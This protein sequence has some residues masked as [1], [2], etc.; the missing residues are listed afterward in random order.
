[1]WFWHWADPEDAPWDALVALGYDDE[2]AARK[3]AAVAAHRSQVAPLSAAPGDEVLLGPELLD[4]F[5]G[6]QEV[7]LE[8]A[9]TDPTLEDLHVKEVDPWGATRRWY[10]HR[11]RDL[12][13]AALPRRRFTRG[14]ELG[15]SRGE[16]A[17]DLAGRCDALVAVDRSPAAIARARTVVPAHVETAVLDV[18]AQ[19]PAGSFDLVVLSEV[20]YFLSPVA[21]EHLL[22]RVAGCL[23]ERG[24]VVLCHWRHPIDGWVLD[25]ADVHDRVLHTV[26]L[27]PL[28]ARYRDDDVEVLVLAER[29]D[30]P[31]PHE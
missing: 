9:V 11:K 19:W 21:L 13:L 23:S 31:D 6:D 27:P 16:L 25:G 8:D 14:L 4:H 3:T 5:P 7:F 17:A 10:E 22:G 15:C 12:V 28:M 30:R 2:A 1:M 26:G 18:P 20:G 29:A 24:V